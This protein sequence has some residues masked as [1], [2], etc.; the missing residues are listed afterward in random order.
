MGQ[1]SVEKSV[2]PGSDLSGNQHFE[3]PFRNPEHPKDFR[4]LDRARMI[5]V[6][7]GFAMGARLPP[8]PLLI[9]PSR[10]FHARPFEYGVLDGLHRF[11]ASVAAGF[12]AVPASLH[13]C[14]N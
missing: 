2:S 9:L 14:E 5:S 10:G 4:G 11:Y 8:I 7:N 1:I 6:L 13:Q 3:P 12:N